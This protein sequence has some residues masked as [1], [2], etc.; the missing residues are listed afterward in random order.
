[1][2]VM[3]AYSSFNP[4][5][6]NIVMDEKYISLGD[7]FIAF[8]SGFTI[9]S[10][11]GHTVY[12]CKHESAGIDITALY[13]VKENC[14]ELYEGKSLGLAFIMVKTKQYSVLVFHDLFFAR[15]SYLCMRPFVAP[16]L[17]LRP[18]FAWK[19]VKKWSQFIF[20]GAR[21]GEVGNSLFLQRNLFL[22]C[23]N[24]EA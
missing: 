4:E 19:K 5:N 7:F 24:G 10:L 20:W 14:E 16:E 2:G 23:L 6:Q 3:T 1:M 12:N 11:L 13:G 21:G 15:A 9:Y 17:V 22:M 18:R 8:S